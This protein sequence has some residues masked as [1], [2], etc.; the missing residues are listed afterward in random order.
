MQWKQ[1]G[2][3]A[4]MVLVIASFGAAGGF[5]AAS[6][7][8]PQGGDGRDSLNA[9][10]QTLLTAYSEQPVAPL[11][12]DEPAQPEITPTSGTGPDVAYFPSVVSASATE[13][14]STISSE[15]QAIWQQELADLPPEQSHEIQQLRTRLGSIAAQSLGLTA[16][17]STTAEPELVDIP[18]DGSLKPAEPRA[19]FTVA[20]AEQAIRQVSVEDRARGGQLR[21]VIAIHQRNLALQPLPGFRRSVFLLAPTPFEQRI[22]LREGVSQ[23]TE[24]PLDVAISGA[25]WFLVKDAVTGT[26]LVTRCGLLTISDD[27]K[28]A[29]KTPQRVLPLEP[30]I[31]VPP[32]AERLEILSSGDCQVWNAE[33]AEPQICGRIKL[34]NCLN[35]SQ[36]HA[37][38]D[39]CYVATDKSGP[40]W[41][42]V[43]GERGLGTLRSRTLERSN[44]DS[45]Y[46]LDQIRRLS[47][48]AGADDAPRVPPQ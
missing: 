20:D 6:R 9:N 36:L 18:R 46:E 40:I 11:L 33:S 12:P 47:Q 17:Q 48:M 35:A 4:V 45:E 1:I 41:Q 14:G 29:I 34:A 28:L 39:G 21:D 19:K 22:D 13:S 37:T 3:K 16:L 26:Q 15:Q 5:L 30:E 31:L 42:A 38:D 23:S 8:L 7:P 10:L 27:R 25:G 43:P 2:G 32:N 24:N 44:V